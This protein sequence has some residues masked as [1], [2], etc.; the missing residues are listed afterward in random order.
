[1]VRAFFKKNGL[2][3]LSLGLALIALVLWE[4][5]IPRY[6]LRRMND[7]GLV[8][9]TPPLAFLALICLV[10]SFVL[11]LYLQRPEGT[12]ALDL[13]CLFEI[14]LAIFMLY[15]ITA[16]VEEVPRF[17]VTW[18]HSGFTDY[19]VRTGKVATWMDARFSW[20]GFFT[21]NA[22]VLKIAGF[23]NT[24]QYAGWV[25]AISNWLYLAP[26]LIILRALSN[27]RRL[28]WLGAWFFY[29]T[30][31][32]GQDY[33]SPQGFNLF[34]YLIGLAIVLRWFK[35]MTEGQTFAIPFQDR[36]TQFKY[37]R[38]LVKAIGWLTPR[39]LP[40]APSDRAQRMGLL[41]VLGIIG[42]VTASSHQLTPIALTVGIGG[43]VV[44]LRTPLRSLP[45]LLLVLTLAWII[46]MTTDYLRGH[47]SD[48][49][50][51]TGQV[52]NAVAANVTN[53]LKGS[54]EHQ[55]V[56]YMRL[57][58]TG[59]I[60]FFAGLGG[61]RRLIKGKLDLTAALLVMSPFSVM[62]ANSYGGEALLRI[63]LFALPF[64]VYL[65]AALFYPTTEP[66]T[67]QVSLLYTGVIGLL[68]FVLLGGFLFTRYGNERMDYF[69]QYEYAASQWLVARAKPGSIVVNPCLNAPTR[70]VNIEDWNVPSPPPDD[71]AFRTAQSVL[72][73][74]NMPGREG[75]VF[76]THS[77]EAYGE[78]FL[79]LPIGWGDK[80][81]QDML[82]SGQF[83]LIYQNQDAAIF[84]LVETEF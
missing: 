58:M 15:G 61:L 81:E 19:I 76:F 71:D 27:D 43:L 42:F 51:D 13:L 53:R 12:R 56:L 52:S 84:Q 8:S 55:I 26:L 6:N 23:D 37:G 44:F 1:M 10:V 38:W 45:V 11:A 25:S 47:I 33:F 78:L 82:A 32:I 72:K 20:P 64:T 9:V 29:L 31:W 74:Y 7:L 65:S 39:D 2:F 63:Y 62:A 40:N 79:G 57:A 83:K 17:A 77:Q 34:F 21:L 50:G 4:L 28:I 30:N 41:L 5:A 80:L 70:F 73:T 36:L 48:V 24:I 59:A 75:Y 16:Q 46:F 68:S 14:L 67:H 54:T 3:L 22:F 66:R 49:T 35:S 69:T 18:L 60:W